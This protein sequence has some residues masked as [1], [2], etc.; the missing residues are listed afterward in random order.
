MSLWSKKIDWHIISEYVNTVFGKKL[1][2][3][4]DAYKFKGNFIAGRVYKISIDNKNFY[5]KKF[6]LRKKLWVRFLSFSK[7]ITE[8]NNLSLFHQLGIPAA[9]VVAYG[10]E[11]IAWIV[12]RGLLITEELV[13][14]HDLDE[15]ADKH[16]KQLQNIKWLEQVSHQVAD[17]ARKMHQY[18]FA[19]SDFKWR[20]IM[21]N[22]NNDNPQRY[23]QN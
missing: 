11:A 17:A 13:D 19:H 9:K 8:Y 7:V 3:F 14:C 4:D 16:P 22:I 12:Q 15:I 10:Q 21:V 1:K 5:L 20:N 2:F 23:L 18:Q 6:V